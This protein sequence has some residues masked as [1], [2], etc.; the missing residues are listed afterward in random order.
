MTVC[1]ADVS[2]AA[3]Y[4]FLRDNS[5]TL[6]KSKTLYAVL[7]VIL[8]ISAT[9]VLYV[10]G[11]NTVKN[12]FYNTSEITVEVT[13]YSENE[14]TAISIYFGDELMEDSTTLKPGEVFE[15]TYTYQSFKLSKDHELKIRLVSHGGDDGAKLDYKE[16]TVGSG[17]NHSVKMKA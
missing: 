9:G 11:G 10:F 2:V 5:M 3:R 15:K 1:C 7:A 8:V 13:S 4:H 17:Q 14:N 12:V 16:V 6:N